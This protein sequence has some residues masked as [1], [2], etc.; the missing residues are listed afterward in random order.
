MRSRNLKG[1]I[2][3][4]NNLRLFQIGEHV[5][6]HQLAALVIAIWIIRLQHAQAVFNGNTGRNHQKTAR[7][8]AELW[9]RRTALMVCQAINIAI[10]VVF[11]APVANLSANLDNSGLASLLAFF[12]W[13]RKYL[14]HL[15]YVRRNLSEPYRGFYCFHLTEKRAN[16]TELVVSPMPKQAGS[17]RG[18]TPLILVRYLAP[19]INLPANTVNSLHQIVLLIIGPILPRGPVE[20]KGGL[21]QGCTPLLLRRRNR[22]DE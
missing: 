18:H 22:R 11:P 6:R 5:I 8:P 7:E 9:G 2:V 13:S 19:L 21:I 16:T 1:V 10:T 12:R 15:P 17:L 3:G 20:H 4:N 14:T